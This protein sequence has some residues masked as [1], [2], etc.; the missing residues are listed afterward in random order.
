ML[1]SGCP[2]KWHQEKIVAVRFVAVDRERIR[3]DA[4]V[5]VG[6]GDDHGESAVV[7]R[8]ARRR[9]LAKLL[10]NLVSFTAGL[11]LFAPQYCIPIV[12]LFGGKWF[13]C[14][15]LRG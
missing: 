3:V 6:A 14:F 12:D 5:G 9:L 7:A 10:A 13:Q 1:P 15:V 8:G 11:F 2:R 4:S